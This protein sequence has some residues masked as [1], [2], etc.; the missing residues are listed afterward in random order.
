VKH[1]ESKVEKERY[2]CNVTVTITVRKK[3]HFTVDRKNFVAFTLVHHRSN[4]DAS[5]LLL[6]SFFVD[7]VVNSAACISFILNLPCSIFV[8][9]L[10]TLHGPSKLN[11]FEQR[12]PFDESL[13]VFTRQEALLPQS[14]QSPL[15]RDE[16]AETPVRPGPRGVVAMTVLSEE[17]NQLVVTS[18]PGGVAA[19]CPPIK[20]DRIQQLN[21]P[22][23]HAGSTV[24]L[25]LYP[26][27]SLLRHPNACVNPRGTNA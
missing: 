5:N 3:V 17:L 7:T 10:H 22:R 1:E 12:H 9:S 23:R 24:G 6:L 15:L 25:E 19:P 8:P 18:G 21:S 16:A 11:A 4:V 14:V 2:L 27:A 20:T 26:L 13:Q